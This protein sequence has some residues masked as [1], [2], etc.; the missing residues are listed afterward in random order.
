MAEPASGGLR[1]RSAAGHHD[2]HQRD[3]DLVAHPAGGVLVHQGQ[4]LA[5]A[6]EIMEVEP[7][8]G[9]DHGRRPAGDLAR[10]HAAQED[11]H[12]QRRHLLVVH[13]TVGVAVDHPVD[14]GIGQ[15]SAVALGPD[16][17]RRVESEPRSRVCS[18][19]ASRLVVGTE[20]VGQQFRQRTRAAGMV[21]QHVGPAVLQQHLAAPA[22]R[23]EQR[24]RWHPRTTARRAV[25]RRRS[26]GRRPLNTRHRD[27]G[28]MRHSP[29]C[30]RPR[31]DHRRSAQPPRPGTASTAHTP[32][33]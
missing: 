14:R 32:A 28:H 22:A 10:R 2:G 23:H 18:S 4:W 27:L 5:V 30:S 6:P 15:H 3:G 9:A 26:A 12:Q 25:R 19:R 16:D 29:H 1:H 11:R 13:P 31:F 8:A 7:L 21:D 33:T 17:G 24:R 20:G